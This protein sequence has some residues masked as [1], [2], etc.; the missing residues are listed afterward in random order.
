VSAVGFGVYLLQGAAPVL[1]DAER[2]SIRRIPQM[3]RRTQHSE[4]KILI[5]SGILDFS[6]PADNARHGLLSPAKGRTGRSGAVLL[7]RRRRFTRVARLWRLPV[8]AWMEGRAMG[9][10]QAVAYAL[11]D[12]RD[13]G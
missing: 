10:E 3:Y 13:I 11:K 4:I 1:G 8:S 7:D 5:L 2:R 9:F 12:G 6:T